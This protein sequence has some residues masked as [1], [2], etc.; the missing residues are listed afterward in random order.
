MG[1]QGRG[2]LAARWQLADPERWWL[3]DPVA[4]HSRIDKPGG[5]AG[6]W[7]RPY[8]PGLQCREIKPQP[9]IENSCGGWGSTRRNSQSH[10]RVRWRDPQGPRACTSPPTWDS[11]PEGPNLIV[12]SRGSNWN[13]AEWSK[14]H[15]SL[16][17]PPPHTV[18]Q[19]SDQHYPPQV[20]T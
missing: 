17:A 10:R 15:C 2:E 5:M 13:P 8:N 12:G 6:E 1:S 18:S 11:A 7:S 16:S 20:N 19:C 4:P 3:A 14:C 9:L